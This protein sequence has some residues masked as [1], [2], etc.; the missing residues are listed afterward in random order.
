MNAQTLALK[1]EL[2]LLK[3]ANGLLGAVRR[4][5][6]TKNPIA[7]YLPDATL[8]LGTIIVVGNMVSVLLLLAK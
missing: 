1:A 2:L 5:K 8:A 6:F 3:G 4:L 7:K